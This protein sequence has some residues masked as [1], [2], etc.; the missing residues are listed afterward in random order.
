MYLTWLES[1]PVPGLSIGEIREFDMAYHRL[2]RSWHRFVL[3]ETD[4][5][6]GVL[7]TAVENAFDSNGRDTSN[8]APVIQNSAQ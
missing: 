2:A 7:L 4:K 5:A 1:N 6:A 8:E 3:A